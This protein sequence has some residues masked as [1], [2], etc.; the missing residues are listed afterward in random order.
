MGA[1]ARRYNAVFNS[2]KHTKAQNVALEIASDD[3][4]RLALTQL[5][6]FTIS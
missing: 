5:A 2:T 1:V 6:Y 4:A 3:M